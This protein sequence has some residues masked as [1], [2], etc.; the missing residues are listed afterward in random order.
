[1]PADP[2]DFFAHL[3]IG[4]SKH[5]DRLRTG[6]PVNP[7]RDT[8]YPPRPAHCHTSD[9]PVPPLL[10]TFTTPPSAIP[11]IVLHSSATEL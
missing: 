2:P 9:G 8:V 4:P 3:A 6:R 10:L 5:P 1:M 11:Y 7:P